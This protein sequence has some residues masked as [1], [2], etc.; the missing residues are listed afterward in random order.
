VIM[1][2]APNLFLRSIE[3]SVERVITQVH[4]GSVTAEI[5]NSE[6]GIGHA[7]SSPQRRVPGP[8]ST[9]QIPNSKLRIR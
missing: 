5:R 4:Q 2:V 6:S 9:L 8:N 7:R 1:G 3:P